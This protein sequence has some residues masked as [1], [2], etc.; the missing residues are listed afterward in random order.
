M[1]NRDPKKVVDIIRLKVKYCEEQIRSVRKDYIR[2]KERLRKE[3]RDR[4]K[5]KQFKRLI[6]RISK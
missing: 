2:E 4:N 1:E 5:M 3:F 6:D